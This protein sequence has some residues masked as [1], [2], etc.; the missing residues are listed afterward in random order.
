MVLHD[1]MKELFYPQMGRDPLVENS[2]INSRPPCHFVHQYSKCS[3]I[4]SSLL[5]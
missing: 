4:S 1:P 2:L 3:N 5:T